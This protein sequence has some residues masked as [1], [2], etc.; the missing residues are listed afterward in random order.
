MVNPKGS[1]T[2][3]SASICTL[4]YMIPQMAMVNSDIDNS[5]HLLFKKNIARRMFQRA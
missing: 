5:L 2:F 4:Q 1:H 3:L